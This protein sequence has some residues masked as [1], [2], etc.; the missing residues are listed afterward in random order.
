MTRDW[1]EDA[2]CLTVGDSEEWFPNNGLSDAA[3]SVCRRCP[4]QWD[5][6]DFALDIQPTHGIWG[7]VPAKL[8]PEMKE[9]RHGR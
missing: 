2:L 6:L 5:C 8:L 3:T 7:G 4:V 9:N 1:R